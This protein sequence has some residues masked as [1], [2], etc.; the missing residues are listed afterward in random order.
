MEYGNCVSNH[1][2]YDF[3][4]LRFSELLSDEPPTIFSIKV[5]DKKDEDWDNQGMDS[6][7][8]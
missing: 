4:L 8:V 5:V 6:W 3:A 1:A 2:A 7:F